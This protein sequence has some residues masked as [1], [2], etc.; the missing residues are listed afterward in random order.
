MPKV[1]HNQG[2]SVWGRFGYDLHI[3]VSGSGMLHLVLD[4]GQAN[5]S[6]KVRDTYILAESTQTPFGLIHFACDCM[7]ACK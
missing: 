2:L 4:L 1:L 5:A 3:D 6:R 7:P